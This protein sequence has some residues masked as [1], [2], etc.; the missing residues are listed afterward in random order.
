MFSLFQDISRIF[1][2]YPG[3]DSV[4]PASFPKKNNNVGFD[5]VING[6]FSWHAKV[7]QVSWHDLGEIGICMLGQNYGSPLI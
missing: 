1:K 5:F 2:I 3:F 7:F 6:H 4:T